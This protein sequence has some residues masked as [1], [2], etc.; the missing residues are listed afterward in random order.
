MSGVNQHLIGSMAN[1]FQA[2]L[3]ANGYTQVAWEN[4][5]FTPPAVDGSTPWFR[6][7]FFPAET[8]QASVGDA[9]LNEMGGIMLINIFYPK[10]KNAG[11]PNQI[12]DS[13]LS[14]FKRGTLT[15]AVSG[16]QAKIF[17]AWRDSALPEEAWYN[18]PVR[19]RYFQQ[20]NNI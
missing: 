9:G 19:V 3:T 10:G 14:H 17:N 20:V 5:E 1:K 16:Y 8:R 18:I 4:R 11:T 13:L 12:A 2:W 7:T 6:P 15:D